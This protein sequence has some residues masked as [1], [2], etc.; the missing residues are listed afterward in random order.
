MALT[1]DRAF[2]ELK[3]NLE[4]TGLQ[5]ET[6]SIR[7]NKVRAVIEEDFD[8]SDSF[9]AG[10]YKRNTM[11][12]PLKQADVDIFIVLDHKYWSKTGQAA[13]LE[14]VKKSLLKT[15]TK[16]PEI[17][18]DGHAV[19]ITFTDFKVDVVPAFHRKGGGY[20]IPDTEMGRWLPTD[21]LKHVELW[22]ASN[23]WH[24]GE[25]IPL[26][27]M[28]KGWNASRSL[29]KSFHLETIAY[30]AL[31]GITILNYPSGVRFVLGKAS[32]LI[33][34]QLPDPAGYTDDVGA[35]LN[36]EAAIKS[37]TDRLAWAYA[38][39]VDAERH[40][41]WGQSEKAFEQWKLIFK[42]YFPAYG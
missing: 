7:Q 20:L 41:A 26:L 40:E 4:I 5:Q 25:F 10:S 15:Y 24:N 17:R 1:V 2:L 21:P 37:V 8:V 32:E 42:D 19:T 29:L 36:T 13:L 9:L 34:V 28:L 6:V 3:S 38:R 18:P 35:H 30:N 14:G 22:T 12:A 11:I 33:R 23:K 39:A 16:T 31:Q 27:K